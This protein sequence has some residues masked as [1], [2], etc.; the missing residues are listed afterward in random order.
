MIVNPPPY[1]RAGSENGKVADAARHQVHL[2]GKRP[3]LV[4]GRQVCGEL[5][6]RR[7]IE[8]AVEAGR[9]ERLRFTVPDHDST[10]ALS[11]S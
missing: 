4:T 1:G 3:A 10:S 9:D 11:S 2:L 6:V 7:R 5:P 8:R